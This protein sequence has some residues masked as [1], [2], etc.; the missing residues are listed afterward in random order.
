[1][2]YEPKSRVIR[3]LEIEQIAVGDEAEL[4]HI[5]TQSDVEDFA[6]LTGDY[7]PLHVDEEFARKT[8]FRK[9]VVHGMLSSSFISTMIG[10]L[11]PGQ[12]ALW[13]SQTL[14]FLHQAYVG[15]TLRVTAR[16]KQKS[17][18]TRMLVL[19]TIIT[20]QHNHQLVK[21]DATVKLLEIE[22]RKEPMSDNVTKVVLITGGNGG[23]GA[24][25][26]QSLAADGYAVAV[27]YLKGKDAAEQVVANII[28]AG[29]RSMAV[30]AD[31]SNSENI[32][33]LFSTVEE[34]L[35][36]I[37]N[38]VHCAAPN[39]APQAFDDLTWDSFQ[40]QLDTQVKGAFH[41]VKAALPRMLEAKSGSVVFIG[42]IYADGAP[43]LQQARYVVA[44]AALAAL[45]RS[46]AVEYGPKNIRVNVIAPGM[47]QTNMIADLPE[48]VKLLARMQTPLR[49]LAEPSDIANVVSFLLSTKA[50]HITGET[51][52][53]CGGIIMT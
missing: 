38:I 10:M 48:K 45:A 7:N 34:T 23:I 26:A 27:N 39:N 52:R 11:L 37:T 28:R 47:T 12:G 2:P 21:G 6:R 20:N 18:S 43:P 1:M 22:E 33:A 36:P 29:G 17:P 9:P 16:V 31:I 19:E 8:L 24:S 4:I 50:N 46:L 49:Q 51:I 40:E 35:G 32:E 41:C 14:Q 3:V 25:I 13:T 30:Q 42:S 15:D 5:L 44:K 53:V